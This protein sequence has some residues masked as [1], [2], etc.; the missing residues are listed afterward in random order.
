MKITLINPYDFSGAGIRSLASVLRSKGHSVQN[1]F[2]LQDTRV[3]IHSPSGLDCSQ[4]VLDEILEHCR[5]QDLLG[6]TL[7][8][9]AFK[10]A[11]KITQRIKKDLNIPVIW[12]GIHPTISPEECLRFVEMICMGEGEA[13]LS[14]LIDRLE[15][16]EDF[17]D[18]E[19]LWLSRKGRVIKNKVPPLIQDIDSIGFDT[20][21]NSDDKIL[22]KEK[23]VAVDNKV[24][25]GLVGTQLQ[26]YFSRGCPYRCSFC[27]N[28]TLNELYK[29][30]K[31]VRYK[32]PEFLIEEIKQIL[33]RF[34]RIRR[35][36]FSDDSFIVAPLKEL[37]RF[38]TLYKQQINLPFSCQVTAPSVSE[39]KIKLLVDAGLNDV[40]M[41]LQSA[42]PRVLKLYNRPISAESVD[43][44]T[45]IVQK[46]L[47]G[48]QLLSYDLILDNPYEA[49]EDLITTLRFLINLPR[50][51]SLRFFSLQLYPGT[52]LY[53][54]VLDDKL[55][56]KRFRDAYF[57]SY[58]SA[59]GNYL[60]FL[61]YLMKLIGLKRCPLFVGRILLKDGM[62]RLLDR[63]F[64]D[65]TIKGL[66]N[67][68]SVWRYSIKLRI[69]FLGR[70]APPVVKKWYTN[71]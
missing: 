51:Y 12:G 40:R 39:E 6:I 35:V 63:P 48:E 30:Q 62:L 67:I 70:Q 64:V 54:K 15:R 20:L 38:T 29:N 28:N 10:L 13:P 43:K 17:S 60:N 1:I 2:L 27:C 57:G 49:K 22:R 34:E 68:R 32:S 36:F 4:R 52:Q 5:D 8:T 58:R 31:I 42:S 53:N 50:P 18:V 59:R 24:A 11:A 16:A 65:L 19:G 26:V 9:S 69:K 45:R 25:A 61:L 21:D 44:A 56:L 14:N 33:P 41:G 3:L 46:C 71:I 7:M 37:E 47:K 66:R 55:P 23:L